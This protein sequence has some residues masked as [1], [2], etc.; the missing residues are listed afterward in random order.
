MALY[1][2]S[3]PSVKESQA[4]TIVVRHVVY[5]VPTRGPT[6]RPARRHTRH[7]TPSATV[8][9]GQHSTYQPAYVHRRPTKEKYGKVRRSQHAVLSTIYYRDLLRPNISEHFTSQREPLSRAVS[10]NAMRRQR[11]FRRSSYA[12]APNPESPAGTLSIQPAC[13]VPPVEAARNSLLNKKIHGC[14]AVAVGRLA[15][16]RRVVVGPRC[17]VGSVGRRRK[18]EGQWHDQRRGG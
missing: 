3:L 6:R 10:V 18:T 7:T 8:H 4:V 13:G 17:I 1:I 16:E 9:G 12:P 15:A 11:H 5:S 14:A 2:H